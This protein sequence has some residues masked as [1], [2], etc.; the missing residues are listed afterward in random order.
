MI[1]NGDIDRGFDLRRAIKTDARVAIVTGSSRGIGRA[2]AVE[3]A[4]AGVCV[5]VNND[6]NVEEALET[7]KAIRE[8]GHEAIYFEADVSKAKKANDLFKA[9]LKEYG[10]VDILINNAGI[11][12][13][14]FLENMNDEDWHSVMSVIVTGTYNCTKLATGIMKQRMHGRIINITSVVGQMGNIG[15]A[16]YAAAKAAVIGFTKTIAK[17]C[18][19]YGITANAVSPGFIETKMLKKIPADVVPKILK[20]IPLGR[21]GKPEE[22]AKLVAFLASDDASYITGQVF[23]INGGMYM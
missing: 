23:N 3:L 4:K 18:A 19:R 9:A 15:Q 13:D 22:V 21:F 8:S 7:V 5:V 1:C 17:E 12:K 20:Q 16:N 10:K 6:K 2:I 14:A 11:I